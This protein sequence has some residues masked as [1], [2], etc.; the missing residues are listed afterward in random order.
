MKLKSSLNILIIIMFIS[1]NYSNLQHLEAKN[2]TISK[3]IT[4]VK[5]INKHNPDLSIKSI[6]NNTWNLETLKKYGKLNHKSI[7]SIIDPENYLMANEKTKLINRINEMNVNYQ[8][9][10]TLILIGSIAENNLYTN[11][12]LKANHNKLSEDLF[13]SNLFPKDHLSE[14]KRI[15]VLISINSNTISIYNGRKVNLFAKE[16]EILIDESLKLLN[17]KSYFDMCNLILDKFQNKYR[18]AVS[19]FYEN[20]FIFLAFILFLLGIV[21]IYL[22]CYK[23]FE[24]VNK[25]MIKSLTLD[26][27]KE[28][29]EEIF[30]CENHYV[31]NLFTTD[32]KNMIDSTNF[33][34]NSSNDI[35]FALFNLKQI[36]LYYSN[37]GIE[38]GN[39]IEAR[40]AI[41]RSPLRKITGC[42][43]EI[44]AA[45]QRKGITKLSK[46]FPAS[47]FAC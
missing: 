32:I 39:A 20:A 9:L 24:R 26:N 15:L 10:I 3:E 30:D 21:I 47:E 31:K 28:K 2:K 38:K 37:N 16:K 41:A 17:K 33:I 43:F 23:T 1:I 11:K 4:K 6:K 29:C 46:L 7:N 25:D 27:K 36:H 34:L 45:T 35:T 19:G 18:E 8:S 14:L 12:L 42:L 44:S 5:V 22:N 40:T 13:Y